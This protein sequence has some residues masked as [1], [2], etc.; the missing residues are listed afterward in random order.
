MQNVYLVLGSFVLVDLDAADI[1]QRDSR[2]HPE[3]S[4]S[5]RDRGRIGLVGGLGFDRARSKQ[6]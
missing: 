3:R 6:Q 1:G 4:E 5:K 2:F